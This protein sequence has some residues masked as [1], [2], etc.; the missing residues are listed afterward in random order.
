MFSETGATVRLWHGL[1]FRVR[2]VTVKRS[3]AAGGRR[4]PQTA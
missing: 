4:Q 2:M 1:T 3:S